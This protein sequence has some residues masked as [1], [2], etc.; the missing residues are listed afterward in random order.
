MN[1]VTIFSTLFKYADS[2]EKTTRT[3]LENFE[4]FSHILKE[5][6]GEKRYLGVFSNPTAIILNIKT[7]V[8]KKI[9]SP[10]IRFSNFVIEY[11]RKNEKV[12]KTTVAC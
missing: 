3:L 6:S 8:S 2:T 10:R 12:R 11:F 5:H 7:S 1:S 4:G 9:A